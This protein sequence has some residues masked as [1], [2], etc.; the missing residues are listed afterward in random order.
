M[1]WPAILFGEQLKLQKAKNP[2]L[3][4]SGMSLH[5]EDI[6]PPPELT[7]SSPIPTLSPDQSESLQAGQ[8]LNVFSTKSTSPPTR[9][10]FFKTLHGT[11]WNSVFPNRKCRNYGLISTRLTINSKK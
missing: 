5:Q 11:T 8:S 2:S 10:N 3:P 1:L 9:S 4:R 6:M 7:P